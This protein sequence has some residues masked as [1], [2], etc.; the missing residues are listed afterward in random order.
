LGEERGGV[1]GAIVGNTTVCAVAVAMLFLK[2]N[3]GGGKGINLLRR[4][5]RSRPGKKSIL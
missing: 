1:S 5:R 4:L 3:F 2:K